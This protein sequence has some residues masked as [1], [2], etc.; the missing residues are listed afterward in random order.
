MPEEVKIYKKEIL[1]TR[2]AIQSRVNELAQKISSDYAGETPVLIGILNGVIFFFTDLMRALTIP[3]KM[4]FIRA[5][6]YGADMVSKGTITF[7]KDVEIPIKDKP[8]IIVED[9]VDT[10]L[11]LKHIIKRLLDKE[12]KSI[13]LCALIDKGERRSEEVILDY[14]GFRVDKG[15]LVGYGLDHNEQYRYLQDIYVLR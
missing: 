2:E 14:W 8:V 15:F 5:S 6:S 3:T 9:I 13:R 7:S 12:P 4:D 10:G 11:T 1:F